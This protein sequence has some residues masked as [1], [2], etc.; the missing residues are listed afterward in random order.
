VIPVVF[1]GSNPS[2]KSPDLT[3]F[4]PAT[5]SRKI[6]DNWI[7]SLQTKL[8]EE[9]QP[10]FLNVSD[11]V[12][13]KNKP[14]KLSEMDLSLLL[15]KLSPYLYKYPIVALGD[16][17]TRA[18]TRSEISHA[19]MSH[20]SGRNRNLNDP[21]FVEAKLML[22]ADFINKYKSDGNEGY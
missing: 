6:L 18:L 1:I 11:I 9:I 2:S 15:I 10:I 12:T 4:H 17:A 14:I 21:R 8:G 19:T 22:L 3:P 16:T 5:R 20:P 13:L 7:R